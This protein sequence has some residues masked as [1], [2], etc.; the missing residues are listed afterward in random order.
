MARSNRLAEETSP[1][2]LLHQ[3]NPVDWYPWGPE[4]LRRAREENKP[5]F[6]SVGYATCFWCHVMERESFADAGTA[7]LMN[8]HFINVKVD[9]EERPDLDE[10]Y[11]AATQLFTQQ[12]GWPNS[13]FLTPELRPFFAGTY[14]PL[15]DRHGR[16]S[17][18]TV[19]LSMH[20]AWTTRREDVMTQAA[21]M[22]KA[23]GQMLEERGTPREEPALSEEVVEAA[24]AGLVERF[25][26]A[27]GGFGNAPKF[28]S[29]ANL[30]L[31]L[32]LAE[33]GDEEAAEM[34][35]VTLDRMGRGG[36]YDQLAGGFHRYATDREWKVPHFEKMLYDNALLI[37]LLTEAWRETQDPV[38]AQR[39]EETVDWLQREMIAEGGGFAAS[40]DADS[41]GVE[42]KFYVWSETEI[43]EA[44]GT[45]DAAFFGSHY[46]ITEGGNWDGANIP[47]RLNS[48]PWLGDVDEHRLQELRTRL[49]EAR[50]T[51]T[52][53]GWDDKVLADWNGLMI[54][55]LAR[56]GQVFDRTN[57]IDTATNAYTFVTTHM[58]V[59][60]R[61]QHAWRKGRCN[62]PGTASDHAN[63]IWAALRLY[64]ATNQP[65]FLK[66]AENLTRSLN[67]HYW[68][69]TDHR[70]ATSAE[71]TS[72]VIVRLASGTDDATPN[73]NG[74]MVS[75]LAAL[76]LIT[77]N[78]DYV[79]QAAQIVDSFGPELAGNLIGY[80]GL[81]AAE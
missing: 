30:H 33:D 62:A 42:G 8:E 11:M 79:Q 74:I 50:K 6:L 70:Y 34:V 69:A 81:L 46:D 59:E 53:P 1:Y 39:I 20:N 57:W 67:E 21:E 72:D 15:A 45:K 71:D 3:N 56:A 40:L 24:K 17:F 80:T 5:I 49:F 41:E 37:D 22:A 16:P 38:Y 44:I 19:L 13:V 35:T 68:L 54:A 26:A 18:R 48:K 28:P 31:L 14:F 43:E 12:G 61:L 51:R 58:I 29:P 55:A 10:I 9:R 25:D 64:Q 36:V 7:A 2:L 73:A 63:L 76:T 32:D 4:A 47:N 77:G 60:G 27:W 65:Q 78:L 23:M 75:N 52:H 66:D